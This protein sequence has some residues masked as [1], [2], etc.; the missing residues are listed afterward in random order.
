[1][2]HHD[3]SIVSLKKRRFLFGMACTHVVLA[4]GEV[5]GWTALRPV[6]LNSGLFDAYNETTTPTRCLCNNF[7]RE[8][9]VSFVHI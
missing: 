6:L 3:P 5:Y 9:L 1:M 7:Q 8:L 2:H 4:S